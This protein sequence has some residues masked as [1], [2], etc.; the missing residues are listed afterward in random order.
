MKQTKI[1]ALGISTLAAVLLTASVVKAE[2]NSNANAS[3]G[4]AST[5]RHTERVAQALGQKKWVATHGQI[6]S[7]DTTTRVVTARVKNSNRKILRDSIVQFTLAND[8]TI[9]LGTGF[10]RW[11][12]DGFFVHAGRRV[13]LD[14]L[15]PGDTLILASGTGVRATDGTWTLTAHKMWAKRTLFQANL[16]VT[17]VDTAASPDTLTGV[18]GNASGNTGLENGDTATLRATAGVKVKRNG[19]TA[20]WGDVMPSDLAIAKG[21][22]SLSGGV[23]VFNVVDL[24]AKSPEFL[25]NENANTNS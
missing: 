12:E 2:T 4:N 14:K 8:A 18:I 19:A 9:R 22:I 21:Y 17:A 5:V 11:F 13:T 7:V 23:K 3:N 25:T 1:V 6:L 16:S 10:L 20:T 15:L 24:K